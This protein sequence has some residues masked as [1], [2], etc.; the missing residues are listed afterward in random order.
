MKAKWYIGVFIF[1]LSLFVVSQ[2]Q[3][4]VPNQEIVV[5]FSNSEASLLDTQQTIVIVKK[6]LQDIG[7]EN[8]QVITNENGTLK[9]T[10]FSDLDVAS[11]KEILSG[12]SNNV[13]G[14]TSVLNNEKPNETPF[15]EDT[16]SYQLDIYKIQK[17]TDKDCNSKGLALE[18]KTEN[19]RFFNP[20]VYFTKI[21]IEV[22]ESIKI[23]KVAYVIQS[24]KAAEIDNSTHNIPEVRAGPMAS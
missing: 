21:E 15:G 20:D 17:D 24:N 12:N 7:A 10:Y 2:Q 5:Q 1:A 13:F 9:I 14:F 23:E 22:S 11:V 8:I 18:L 16:N 3:I 19:I 4:A 6:Q